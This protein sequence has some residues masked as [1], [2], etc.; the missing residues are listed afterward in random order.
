MTLPTP[1]T[2]LTA[3]RQ[4]VPVLVVPRPNGKSDKLPLSATG[5]VID[6]HDPRHWLDYDSAAR[7]S[8]HVGF[9]I[10]AA[11]GFWCLDIDGAL[12]PDNT[13]SPLALELTGM[14]P[15]TVV[16]VSH[17]GKGLHIWGRGPIPEHRKKNVTLA[18]ELYSNS[19]FILIG[20]QANGTMA[21]TVPGIAAVVE[22]Y[23]KPADMTVSG[24]DGPRADWRGPTDDADLI[25]R[26]LASHSATSVFGGGG[27]SFRDLWERNVDALARAYPATGE[28]GP[29]DASSADAALVA[30]LAW[31]TGCDGPRIARL[32]RQSALA[33]DKYDR[34]DYLP[35]TIEAI[36][37]KQKG[38]CQDK[39]LRT[40]AEAISE[41]D[42]LPQD[43]ARRKLALVF[44]TV[45]PEEQEL[46][47]QYAEARA[48]LTRRDV[49]ALIRQAKLTA[50]VAASED[51]IKHRAQD[52]TLIR[53][54]PE[55]S[56]DIS[57]RVEALICQTANPGEYVQFGGAL[58]RVAVK[59]LPHT[60]ALDRPGEQ[61]APVPHIEP[62]DAVAIRALVERV[63]VFYEL[64]KDTTKRPVGV[65]D[66]VVENLLG[67]SKHEADEVS[68]LLTHPV[69]LTSGE[70]LSGPGLH[71]GSRLFLQ[72][73]SLSGARPY[74]HAEAVAALDRLRRLFLAEFE[75][76]STLH[77]DL[78][79]A[80]LFTGVERR[81]LDKAPGVAFL[82][83]MQSSG[84]TTLAQ[85]VHVI[86]TGH[87]MPVSTFP[88]GNEE[89]FG[90]RLLAALMRGPA[91][92]CFDNVPDGFTFHS[93]TL[94][95]AM[96]APSFTQRVLGASREV[97]VP[98]NTLFV[99]T[100]NNL[101]LG[102]D[103][104]TRWL[105]VRLQPKSARPDERKFKNAD[106]VRFAL[107]IRDEVLT[108]VLGVIAGYLASGARYEAKSRFPD[109]D[110]MVRQPLLWSGAQDV[111]QSF[112]ANADESE[113]IRSHRALVHAIRCAFP[114][115]Q[116]FTARSLVAQAALPSDSGPRLTSALENQPIKGPLS[117]KSIGRLLT[118]KVG[119]V[120]T[121]GDEGLKIEQR[122]NRDHTAEFRVTA[123]TVEDLDA[124]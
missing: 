90:K 62:L 104:V 32:M 58:A 41:F 88:S 92:M 37:G 6:A 57:G 48:G 43:E 30:H 47:K 117:P 114:A 59:H 72:G 78:A 121:I 79:L 100:G 51:R 115:G 50:T 123:A 16:E 23:F 18:I 113:A 120:A 24:T 34:E 65:P 82:A 38:V 102:N 118:G 96:T 40:A 63:A 61:S 3:L 91:M 85:R 81:V 27:A 68:G 99:I 106:T 15:G 17:S 42:G 9:V 83:S 4:F 53:W 77:A 97:T 80:A 76:S 116:W 13:W 49:N 31:W 1:L 108:D 119:R 54:E 19:R 10:T 28:S 22:R 46:F 69:V 29:Y 33:R 86:L 45:K 111:A 56:V 35:R 122:T 12:Q 52:R 66:R 39:T 112:T 89:E 101:S 105:V 110:R 26:A 55:S 14:L 84:K 71:R 75:F 74:A 8:P 70:I 20:S 103:E 21:A 2:P 5:E 87:D 95:A 124:R 60:S 107:Q 73:L 67:K 36:A 98:T 11:S 7:V 25:R 44:D 109:W 64:N 93:G 94:A